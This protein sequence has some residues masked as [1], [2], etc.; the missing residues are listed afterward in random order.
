MK[1]MVGLQH[2]N[3]AKGRDG[4]LYVP[5]NFASCDTLPLLVA[6]HGAGGDGGQMIG[7]LRDA[8]EAS[9][10][11]V[12]A[13]E[14]RGATWDLMRG[15]IGPDLDFMRRALAS[16]YSRF[17]VDPDHR[18]ICG[19]SDGASYA[20]TIGLELGEQ[21]THIAAFAPGF[22]APRSIGDHPKLFLAHGSHDRVLPL[23]LSLRLVPELKGLD[24]D[25]EFH[26]FSGGHELDPAVMKRALDWFLA[27]LPP[28]AIAPNR[29]RSEEQGIEFT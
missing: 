25:V 18:G 7:A 11:L 3:L 29:I 13:P 27:P 2:L 14:S 12:L 1:E 20:L 9:N 26:E 4:F 15:G 23:R 24:L 6:L 16:I 22:T 21:F 8:A 10:F 19:F 5:T 28:A 17:A